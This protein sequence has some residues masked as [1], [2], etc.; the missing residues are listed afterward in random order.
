MISELELRRQ[1]FTYVCTKFV[2]PSTGSMIQVGES[3]QL[4]VAPSAV[5]S[6]PMNLERNG[7]QKFMDKYEISL[8]TKTAAEDDQK[9]S[10]GINLLMIGVFL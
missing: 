6:S 4:F 8:N 1:L 3:V 9:N 2:V 10:K 7:E 5:D